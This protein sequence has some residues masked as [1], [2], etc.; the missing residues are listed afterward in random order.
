MKNLLSPTIVTDSI[1]AAINI[2]PICFMLVR[3]ASYDGHVWRCSCGVEAIL[4]GLDLPPP[5]LQLWLERIDAA[6]RARSRPS[7]SSAILSHNT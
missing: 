1:G 2:C 6:A 4:A 5:A 3:E 7:D